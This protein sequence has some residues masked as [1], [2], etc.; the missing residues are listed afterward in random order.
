MARNHDD[1][2]NYF[3]DL[4]DIHIHNDGTVHLDN[5]EHL[6]HFHVVDDNLDDYLD[7]L[8]SDDNHL[9]DDDR[10]DDDDHFDWST[11]YDYDS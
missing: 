3:V 4:D 7:N 1:D 6:H 8:A 2:D 10:A 9:N 5:D 11:V